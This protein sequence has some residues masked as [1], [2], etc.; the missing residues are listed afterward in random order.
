VVSLNEI[1]MGMEALLRRTLGED[2][3]LVA[4]QAPDLGA[5][6][7]MSISFETGIMNLAVNAR[8]AMV[9]GGQL[10]LE[11]GNVELDEKYCRTH[12]EAT[13]GS[14][15]MLEVS[16]MAWAWTKRPSSTSSSRSSPPKHRAWAPP[17]SG[18][19]L[20]HSP[21]EQWSIAVFSEPGKGTSFQDLPAPSD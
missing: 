16:D 19:R 8:D 4:L 15:V 17:R 13:P 3:D 10:T 21:A 1:L 2:I 9:S 7:Q 12:L 11:T 20:R 5:W 14:Y 18:H 6:K